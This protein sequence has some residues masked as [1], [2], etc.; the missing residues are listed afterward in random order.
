MPS[1]TSVYQ[2]VQL[3]HARCLYTESQIVEDLNAEKKDREGQSLN[4]RS[5]DIITCEIIRI[6]IIIGIRFKANMVPYN[7]LGK[8]WIAD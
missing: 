7:F 6:I 3:V 4:Y 5:C 8:M 2:L 1:T